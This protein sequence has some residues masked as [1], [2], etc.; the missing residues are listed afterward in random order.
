MRLSV[1]AYSIPSA[2]KPWISTIGTPRPQTAT[3][4]WWPSASEIV[5][6][7]SCGRCSATASASLTGPNRASVDEVDTRSNRPVARAAF[8]FG[9]ARRLITV[10]FSITALPCP[11]SH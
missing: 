2:V 6:R 10:V 11:P 5:C 4:T 3:P 8:A 9:L 7:S 1:W